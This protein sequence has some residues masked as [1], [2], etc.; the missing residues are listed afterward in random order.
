MTTLAEDPEEL[1]DVDEADTDAT[2]VLLAA[3]ILV[4]MLHD[5]GDTHSLVRASIEHRIRAFVIRSALGLLRG[6][7]I[8]SGIQTQHIDTVA[9]TLVPDVVQQITHSIEQTTPDNRT[10]AVAD[11]LGRSLTVSIREQAREQTASSF[12]ALNKIWRTRHD[13]DVR[14]THRELEGQVRP[15]GQPFEL[16]GIKLM[17]PCDMSAPIELWASC[18]CRLSYRFPNVAQEAR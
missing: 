9:D 17:Y 18:R 16:N 3:A 8:R 7:K 11:M 2:E 14:S 13:E 4:V 15:L 10:Q 12:G 6:S 5:G 1:D